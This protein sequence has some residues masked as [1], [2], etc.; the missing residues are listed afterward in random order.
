M[1]IIKD[2][3]LSWQLRIGVNRES[4]PR[5]VAYDGIFLFGVGK[6]WKATRQLTGF[7]LLNFELHTQDTFIRVGPEM[8]LLANFG[9][10]R[11]T[12]GLDLISMRSAGDFLGR[13]SCRILYR[14]SESQSID[15][16]RRPRSA[17][18]M[19]GISHYF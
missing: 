15:V 4:E 7:G 18:T 9:S 1:R 13:G 17:M 3:G 19:I 14:L 2:R 11:A 8:R 6:A 5:G 12:V 10:L 16:A